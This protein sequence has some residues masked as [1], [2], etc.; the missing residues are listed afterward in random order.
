MKHL[1]FPFALSTLAVL[2]AASFAGNNPIT[3]LS[4]NENDRQIFNIKLFTAAI[5]FLS[6]SIGSISEGLKSLKH[7]NFSVAAMEPVGFAP[8]FEVVTGREFVNVQS[9][10]HLKYR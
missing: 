5:A 9:F 6:G 4:N 8:E 3:S 2:S 7:R 1:K 10:P